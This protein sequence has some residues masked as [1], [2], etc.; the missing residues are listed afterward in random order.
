M[1]SLSLV[2]EFYLI[3]RVYHNFLSI[4]TCPCDKIM[5]AETGKSAIRMCLVGGDYAFE[6]SRA[7]DLEKCK[8][9]I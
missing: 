3:K 1:I 7:L 8:I 2:N 5:E 6:G 4:G 9:P